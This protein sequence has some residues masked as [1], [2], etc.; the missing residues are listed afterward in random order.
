MPGLCFYIAV[1]TTPFMCVH[2]C[3]AWLLAHHCLWM[4]G[5]IFGACVWTLGWALSAVVLW[6]KAQADAAAAEEQAA[7]MHVDMIRMSKLW[8][9]QQDAVP[10]TRLKRHGASSRTTMQRSHSCA[11]DD[12]RPFSAAQ[13][14][15]I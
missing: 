12:V 4:H 2:M 13:L 6:Q 14:K 3:A 11:T 15:T 5:A 7:L 1:L 8:C 10:T 9:M